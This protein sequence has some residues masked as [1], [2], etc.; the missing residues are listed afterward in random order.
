M[1]D[2]VAHTRAYVGGTCSAFNSASLLALHPQGCARGCI[3]IVQFPGRS[4]GGHGGRGIAVVA[5]RACG[6]KEAT[7]KGALTSCFL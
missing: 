3:A 4:S 1:V 7:R 2:V 5:H 6:C